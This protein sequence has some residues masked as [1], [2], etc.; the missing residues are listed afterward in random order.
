MGVTMPDLITPRMALACHECGHRPDPE[1]VM[2]SFQLHYQVEHDS[3]ELHMDLIAVCDCGATMRHVENRPTGGGW[4]VYYHC[5]ACGTDGRIKQNEEPG[6]VGS[7][8][9]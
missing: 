1:S 3:D 2:E 5:E 6:E 4:W 7:D 8:D 9:E